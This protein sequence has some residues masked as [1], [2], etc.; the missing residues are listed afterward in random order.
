MSHTWGSKSNHWKPIPKR[1][2]KIKKTSKSWWWSSNRSVNQGKLVK[3]ANLVVQ[4]NLSGSRRSWPSLEQSSLSI[5]KHTAPTSKSP[6]LN[7]SRS[8]LSYTHSRKTLKT[9]KVKSWPW[10][11]KFLTWLLKLSHFKVSL[12]KLWPR[13]SKWR[14]STR[15][16]AQ[17]WHSCLR[18]NRMS[19]GLRI[20]SWRLS[21]ETCSSSARALRKRTWSGRT[22]ATKLRKSC[23]SCNRR[24]WIL[25][26]PLTWRRFKRPKSTHSSNC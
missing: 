11:A 19:L 23:R 8:K 13:Q 16:K 17:S 1:L 14:R 12:P 20:R 22:S 26:S 24:N 3:K 9:K 5:S 18:Q 4:R 15:A 25:V 6:K 21:S 10:P 2:A 7:F